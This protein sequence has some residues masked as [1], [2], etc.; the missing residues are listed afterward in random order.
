MSIRFRGRAADQKH[1]D[2]RQEGVD[3]GQ[4]MSPEETPAGRRSNVSGVPF[5]FIRNQRPKFL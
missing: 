3:T 5:T 1:E 4:L 2:Q